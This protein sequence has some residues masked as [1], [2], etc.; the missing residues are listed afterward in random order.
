MK[1]HLKY[2]VI[3]VATFVM[4]T[5]I[6]VKAEDYNLYSDGA[7]INITIPIHKTDINNKPLSGAEFSLKDFN[8]TISYKSDDKEDGDYLI[9]V[10]ENSYPIEREDLDYRIVDYFSEDEVLTKI[11]DIIPSK[12]S[13]VFRNAEE[14]EDLY[15]ILDLP[16]TYSF[17]GDDFYSVGFYVPLKIEETK[18]PDGY[19]AK[20]IIVPAFVTITLNN[21]YISS[22]LMYSPGFWDETFFEMIPAYF[23]YKDGIDYEEIF[24]NINNNIEE[25]DINEAVEEFEA[26][27]AI[28]DTDCDISMPPPSREDLDERFDPEIEESYCPINLIDEVE[29]KVDPV[30]VNPETAGTIVIITLLIVL[31]FATTV[32]SKKRKNN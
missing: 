4:V 31:G 6:T 5:C 20:N 28:I 9:H 21:G 25:Y 24:D 19:K 17:D 15:D 7:E 30:I 8:D 18:V 22:S 23:E 12:Y 26:N 13:D 10:Y 2:L 14:K 3:I 32:I 16:L 11:F 1:K 27:G 29:E